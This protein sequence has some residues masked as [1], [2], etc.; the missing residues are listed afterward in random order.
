MNK[1]IF[2]LTILLTL[3][4]ATA[5]ASRGA[6]TLQLNQQNGGIIGHSHQTGMINF[7]G[8]GSENGIAPRTS[9]QTWVTAEDQAV[10]HLDTYAPIFG[11]PNPRQNLQLV[12]TRQPRRGQVTYRYQQTYKDIPIL[13]G[14]ILLNITTEGDLLSL[15]G[16]L[17]PELDL[18][19]TPK[20]SAAEARRKVEN[21]LTLSSQ[22]DIE[23]VEISTPQLWI[24][25]QRLLLPAA[26]LLSWFGDVK[27]VPLIC[28]LTSWF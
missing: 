15:R 20:I 16:E 19:V 7:L 10:D 18:S 5:S 12:S 26:D 3:T 14:E 23:Q 8:A 9:K 17:S 1:R 4:S 25:D 27:R 6:I 11:E 2:F 13:A 28:Q 22:L 21:L 24:F